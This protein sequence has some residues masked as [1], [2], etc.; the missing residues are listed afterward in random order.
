MKD[1]TSERIEYINLGESDE[2]SL[3]DLSTTGACWHSKKRV[4][5]DAV[6]S[7]KIN[8]LILKAKVVY[9]RERSDGFR[10]GLQFLNIS[11]EQQKKLNE[12]V[13]AFSRGVSI[14]CG[15]IEKP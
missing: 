3:F 11:A 9:C 6:V 4:E 10:L 15:V 8:E 13:D 12:C 1:R 2:G 5:K 7:L 14:T